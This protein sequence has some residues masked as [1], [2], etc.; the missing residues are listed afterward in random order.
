MLASAEELEW[1]EMSQGYLKCLS[2]YKNYFLCHVLNFLIFS[3]CVFSLLHLLGIIPQC[4]F[5]L[6]LS[7]WI[8]LT[9]F[10]VQKLK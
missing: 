1:N 3:L 5:P 8:L 9:P 10:V 6:S 2:R 7:S 4:V